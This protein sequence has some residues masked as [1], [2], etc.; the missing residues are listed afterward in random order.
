MA[1]T[2]EDVASKGDSSPRIPKSSA[3]VTK[4]TTEAPVKR[5]RGRPPKGSAPMPKKVYVPTGRP[6]GRPPG[7][8]KKATATGPKKIATIN[9]DG[10]PKK[11]RGR[12]RRAAS[13]AES[14]ATTPKETKKRGRKPKASP[15]AEASGDE[16]AKDAELA[17]EDDVPED[18][19][20]E[21]PAKDEAH[22]EDGDESD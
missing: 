8:G 9:D 20:A 1:R 12:P 2:K 17:D 22:D 4:N 6:R 7:S 11:G 16:E 19:T 21:S 15:A 3:G 14:A 5:G 10:T 18:D 13:G